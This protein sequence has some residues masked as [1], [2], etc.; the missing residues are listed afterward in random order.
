MARILD[1]KLAPIKADIQ[2]LKKNIRTIK[3]DICTIEDIAD[4]LQGDVLT[5]GR[6]DGDAGPSKK[7]SPP[8]TKK[9]KR[10]KDEEAEDGQLSLLLCSGLNEAFYTFSTSSPQ[11]MFFSI[12]FLRLLLTD[13]CL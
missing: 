10:D 1:E 13:I 12:P 6:A 7:G 11:C 2:T 4:I 9:A 5:H 8:P 3:N